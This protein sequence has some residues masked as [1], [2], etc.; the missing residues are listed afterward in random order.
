MIA[1]TRITVEEFEVFVALPENEEL[2]FE[3][4]NGEIVEKVP[5]NA[6]ASEIAGLISFFIHLFLREHRIKGHVTG[7]AG[8]YKVAGNRFAPDV[9][10]ISYE[11]QAEL[12]RQGYN[13]FPPELAVE[14]E[15]NTT[16]DTERRLRAKVL[17]YLAAGTLLWVIYPETKEAEVYA[18]GQ[19]MM[20]LSINDS[21]DGGDVLP[22]FTLPLTEIFK[23]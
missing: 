9:A 20:K 17:S 19:P 11:R 15:T 6:F 2:L 4:I 23:D 21:L 18:P 5:S 10:Y 14:I 3:L 13:E 22:G 16:S 12:N 7:E 1:Q 8:G